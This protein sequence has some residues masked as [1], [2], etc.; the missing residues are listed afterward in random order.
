MVCRTKKDAYQFRRKGNELQNVFNEELK[1][2]SE[3][4]ANGDVDRAKEL[5]KQGSE[6]IDARQK[7]I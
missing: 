4:L 6:K 5:L 1:K 2:A 3:H 7:L